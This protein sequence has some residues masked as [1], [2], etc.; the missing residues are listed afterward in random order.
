[1]QPDNFFKSHD[2]LLNVFVV[3]VKS[4]KTLA[5]GSTVYCQQFQLDVTLQQG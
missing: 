4:G 5:C 3:C 2:L 1:M